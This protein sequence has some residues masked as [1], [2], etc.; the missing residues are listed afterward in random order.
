MKNILLILFSIF[1]SPVCFSQNT[2]DEF[3]K[4]VEMNNLELK[5]LQRQTEGR[6]LEAR[7]GI[8]PANP[9]FEFGY[10]PGDV[11]DKGTM[12]TM[13]ISQKL[14]FPGVYVQKNK[15]SKLNQDQSDLEYQA[16]RIS[17]LAEASALFIQQIHAG[18]TAALCSE[19]VEN[20]NRILQFYEK[21]FQQGDANILELNKLKIELT[22]AKRLE[23]L[24]S[25]QK[26]KIVQQLEL[27]N[28]GKMIPLITENYPIYPET[29]Q[30][31]FEQLYQEKDPDLHWYSG[32]VNVA[33]QEI[34]LE[35]NKSLPEIAFSYGYEKTPEVKYAGPGAALS[36]PLWQNKNKVKLA[37]T[38]WEFSQSKFEE[39]KL[40]RR[41]DLNEKF[42]RLQIYKSSLTGMRKTISDINSLELLGKALNAGEIP[43]ISYLNELQYFYQIQ[44]EILQSEL[45]YQ[46]LLAELNR[47]RL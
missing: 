33:F 21:K 37:R 32:A 25:L 13:K 41:N 14:E 28:G 2:L 11:G 31:E 42:R 35:Q 6:K 36:I 46:L 12:T 40:V 4:S 18:K 8:N 29:S 16:Q 30:E 23:S 9:E 24:A 3:L 44:N 10:L 22:Q 7:T 17:V 39:V 27:V 26:D 1:I 47:I 15:L 19:R 34:K 38:N 20:A 45:E 5:S 43:I